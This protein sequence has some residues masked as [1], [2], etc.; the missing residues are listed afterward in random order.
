MLTAPPAGNTVDSIRPVPATAIAAAAAHA[1]L[2]QAKLAAQGHH[3]APTHDAEGKL[4]ADE[5]EARLEAIE[6]A[7]GESQAEDLKQNVIKQ[8]EAVINAPEA[9]VSTN[10]ALEARIADIE[11]RLADYNKRS[12]Q[13]I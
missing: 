12:G 10:A 1:R 4:L 3:I 9:P 13:K 11:A 7:L 5:K 2:E 6:K 8:A